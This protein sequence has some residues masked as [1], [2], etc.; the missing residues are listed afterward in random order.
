MTLSSADKQRLRALA[1]EIEPVVQMGH[2]GLTDSLIKQTSEA[3]KTH[4][5]IKIK[6]GRHLPEGEEDPSERLAEATGAEL[7]QKIGKVIVLFRQNEHEEDRKIKL[8]TLD[9]KKAAK[10]QP[11]EKTR[12]KARGTRRQFPPRASGGSRSSS[13]PDRRAGGS[14]SGSGPRRPRPR[15]DD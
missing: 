4:E 9:R 8:F 11:G 15:N 1:H 6:L 5:L 2:K 12:V 3:L 10:K 13:S 7:I 14:R